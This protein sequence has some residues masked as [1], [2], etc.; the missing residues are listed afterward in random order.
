MSKER[1]DWL[2]KWA[3]DKSDIIKTYGCESNVK[4]IYDKCQELDKDPNN[5]IFNQFCE[6]G[7]VHCHYHVTG[8]ALGHVF[9]HV[10][11]AHDDKLNMFAFVSATGSAGTISAGDRLKDDFGARIACVES[12]ECP[13]LL[14][15]GFGDHNIQGI[16]DKHVPFIH[17]TMNTDVIVGISD[18]D[19]DSLTLVFTT[20]AGK[21]YLRRRGI[22]E[23]LIELL[24]LLGY[25]GIC[26][27]L[28][29]IK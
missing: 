13:T 7:N 15:N 10:K 8:K 18:V 3:T 17:N 6:F 25:S 19:T 21:A 27:M 16:G 12:Q 2:E 9:S 22:S 26:N 4:E 29:A 28:A 23:K 14:Y 5:V 24:P 11:K 1:F 20:E